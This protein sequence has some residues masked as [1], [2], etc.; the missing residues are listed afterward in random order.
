MTYEIDLRGKKAVVFGIA[1]RHSI[2]W[3]VAKR[4]REAGADLAI[5]Y[6]NERLEQSVVELAREAAAPIV[7]ECDITDLEQLKRLYKRIAAEWGSIDYIVH[8]VAF[9]HRDDLGGRFSDVSRD[10]FRVALETSA[11]SLIPAVAEARDLFGETGGS[12]IAMTFDASM[13]VYPGYNIMGVAKAALENEVRQL[14]AEY[15]P[16]GVR[17]NALSPGP[18]TTL[19]A[20]G[21]PGLNEMKK[22]HR[23]RSPLRRNILHDE[24][25]TAAL[26]MLSDMS[27]GVTGAILP[28]DAGYGI[29]A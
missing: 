13:R 17:V 5:T 23:E 9:A 3:A 28:V 15:G 12:V 10:G 25:A 11:Y 6:F 2:A 27:S 20:R 21:V 19:S 24:V 8:S 1:N 22:V 7:A 26:F 4:L 14:A 16:V 29:L 18:L